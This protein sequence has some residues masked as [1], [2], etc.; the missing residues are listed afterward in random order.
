[1]H[2]ARQCNFHRQVDLL[3]ARPE[4]LAPHLTSNRFF[5]STVVSD[6]KESDQCRFIIQVPQISYQMRVLVRWFVVLILEGHEGNAV[7]PI[8]N[9]AL[10]WD[11]GYGKVWSSNVGLRCSGHQTCFPFYWHARGDLFPINCLKKPMYFNLKLQ[12]STW[13]YLTWESSLFLW[14]T[15]AHKS[16]WQWVAESHYGRCVS[17]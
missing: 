10:R 4:E 17:S 13:E 14:H 8:L 2:R 15:L 5:R 12:A 3:T 16:Q 6:H 11:F 1:M 9:T 7:A